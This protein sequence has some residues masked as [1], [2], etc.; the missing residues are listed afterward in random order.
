MSFNNVQLTHVVAM[1][2]NNCIGV[3]GKLPWHLPADLKR[4][5]ETTINGILVMGRKTYESIGRPLPNRSTWVLTQDEKFNPDGVHVAHTL[6]EVLLAA[7]KQAQSV[8]SNNIFIVGGGEIYVQT[9]AFTD[10]IMATYVESEVDGDTFYP[11]ALGSFIETYRSRH[12]DPKVDLHYNFVDLTANL[13][14]NLKVVGTP[15]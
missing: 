3:D 2:A 13:V 10:R 6:Q 15:L 8:N 11:K 9:L 7:T 5:K 12:Y 4:F 14:T 1:S